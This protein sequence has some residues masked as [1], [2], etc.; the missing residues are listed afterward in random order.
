[1]PNRNVSLY[2]KVLTPEQTVRYCRVIMRG[3]DPHP[4]KVEFRGLI[5]EADEAS[6][7]YKIF[8]LADYDESLNLFN[9]PGELDSTQQTRWIGR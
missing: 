1:M 7:E 8:P 5:F 6:L 9:S 4:K 2:R 3:K